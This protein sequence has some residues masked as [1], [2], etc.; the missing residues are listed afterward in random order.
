MKIIQTT[1][2]LVPVLGLS[3]VGVGGLSGCKS[4]SQRAAEHRREARE[5]MREAQDELAKGRENAREDMKNAGEEASDEMKQANRELSK[6]NEAERDRYGMGTGRDDR[7]FDERYDNGYD[8]RAP[9]AGRDLIPVENELRDKLGDKWLVE[10]RAGGGYVA[11]RKVA[12]TPDD[13]LEK[14]LADEVKDARDD[15]KG[16]TASYTRG[17]VRLSGRIDDC[18]DAAKAAN[19]FAKID[20]VNK[21]VFDVA[22]T[23]SRSML[24]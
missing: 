1:K 7:R 18:G 4:P 19:K 13:D 6:A 10:K 11:T 3:L 15:H 21:V 9:V 20:G 8:T 23:P 2:L 16:M 14:K 5:D 17:E 22:C 24:K 12:V